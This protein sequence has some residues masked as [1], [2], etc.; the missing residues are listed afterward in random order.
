MNIGNY[1]IKKRQIIFFVILFAG[2]AASVYL[3]LNRQ[4]F[5][6]RASVVNRTFDI[7]QNTVPQQPAICEGSSCT[8]ET[9]NVII[10]PN[11]QDEPTAPIPARVSAPASK[12]DPSVGYFIPFRDSSVS[13]A[14][15]EAAKKFILNSWPNAQIGNWN[16]I[17]NQSVTNGWNPAF[18]LTLWIEESG[19][20][21]A[22]GGYSAAL[23]CDITH[24]K[25][26]GTDIN[27]QLTC[28]FNNSPDNF[29]DF[30]CKWGGDKYPAPCKF[31]VTNPNF[32]GGVSGIYSK[33]VPSGYGALVR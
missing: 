27:Q 12:I 3:A 6:P 19:A 29:A 11:L 7:I 16:T 14:D 10:R 26:S 8:T 31:D 13:V 1:Y 30:M 15:P 20:Q 24:T 32:L 33:L 28:L 22:S 5:K 23:G 4:I 2:L 18:I 25:Y 17:V 21:G 9:L